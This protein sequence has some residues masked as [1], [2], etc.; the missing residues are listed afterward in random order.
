MLECEK[1]N[2]IGEWLMVLIFLNAGSTF[3]C[4]LRCESGHVCS[5]VYKTTGYNKENFVYVK[6]YLVWDICV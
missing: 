1:T 2:F 3:N 5:L 4:S 6:P